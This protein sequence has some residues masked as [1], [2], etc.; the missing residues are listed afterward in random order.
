MT[1]LKLQK[2]LAAEV[3]G[4]GKNRVRFDSESLSDIK[5]AITK[6]DIRGLIRDRAINI[7]PKI[8][9]ARHR[10]R[11]RHIQRKKGRQRGVGKRKGKAGARTPK[12]RMW[13]NKIRLQ[14][15]ILKRLRDKK[16]IEPRVYREL[17]LKAKGG[18]FR[19]RKHLLLYLKQQ[20]YL[21]GGKK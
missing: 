7:L 3:A 19:S 5:E 18:F 11:K 2:K 6:A 16:E 12:K 4:V 1:E 17:Y 14:R 9:T 20:G 21:K 13:I 10:A 8:G 15:S